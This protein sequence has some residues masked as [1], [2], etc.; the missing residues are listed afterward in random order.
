MAR[1]RT[2]LIIGICIAAATL[3]TL[4]ASSQQTPIDLTRSYTWRPIRIGAGGWVVGFVTHP[5]NANIRYARTDVG[6]AYSWDSS[7]DEWIP[8]KVVN[9]DGTGFPGSVFSAPGPGGVQSIA[10]DPHNVKTVYIAAPNNRSADIGGSTGI[11]IYKSTNGGRTF[12]PGNLNVPGDPNDGWRMLGERLKVD[13]NNNRV[14]YYGT[15]FGPK[16]GSG[17][18]RSTDAGATWNQVSAPSAFA[19][20]DNIYNIVFNPA[21]GM[22][23][24]TPLGTA[25]GR[26]TKEIW[27]CGGHYVGNSFTS[28]VYESVDGGRT[29]SNASAGTGVSGKVSEIF[30]DSKGNLYA[31]QSGSRNLWRRQHGSWTTL[32]VDSDD[33]LNSL[34]IDP[35]NPDRLFTISNDAST[36]RS[37]DGGKT[38]TSFGRLVYAN[39]FSWLPQVPGNAEAYGYRSTGG[40]FF[41]SGGQLWVCQG[42]E[43]M[44]CY[45]PSGTNTESTANPPKWTISSK[46]IEEFVTQD[47]VVPKG[48][49]DRIY[50]AVEDATG[51]VIAHPDDFSAV[52][53]PLQTNLISQGTQFAVCPNDPTTVAVTASN[54]VSNGKN[55]SGISFDSGKTWSLFGPALRVKTQS[56]TFEAQAGSIA[57]SRRGSWKAGMDHIVQLPLSNIVPEYSKDGGKTWTSTKSFPV[58]PDLTTFN[59]K[60]GYLGFWIFALKQRELYADPFVPD[61]FYLKLVQ[62]PAGLYISTDGGV[63]WLPENDGLPANTHHGQL[64]VNSVV[65]N[66][67]WFVDGWEGANEHGIYHSADGGKSFIKIPNVTNAITV[68]LGKG[69]GQG[70]DE[71]YTVYF[72]GKFSSDPRW[73][74][75]RSTNGGVSWVRVAYYPMGIFDQ[76]TCMAASWETYGNV[77]VGFGGNGCVYGKLSSTKAR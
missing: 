32:V 8:I 40:I 33:N 38:W 34:A 58:T 37:L 41:D 48:G 75:F 24:G 53:V 62:S 19:N 52:Q 6:N 77:Y 12:M 76:P 31:I 50:V 39:T 45:T 25:P 49:G 73:G 26:V 65:K 2:S 5:L 61:K 42:N 70:T 18:F 16:G 57:I 9:D 10:V 69:S 1:T 27:A 60:E 63:T 29:W 4:P 23:T 67:L 74:V 3:G 35:K 66:D 7:K 44:L 51:V 15:A 14:L 59:G 68:A 36:S 56:G 22:T 13:P 71:P 11:N 17:L 47:I 54:S 72:Y 21:N 20:W 28:D 64:A 46:G 30:V 55:Q 43:G